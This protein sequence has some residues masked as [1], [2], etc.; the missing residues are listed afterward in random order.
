MPSP[1]SQCYMQIDDSISIPRTYSRR[2]GAV[3]GA[4][5]PQGASGG[6]EA[7]PCGFHTTSDVLAASDLAGDL[8]V[9][10]PW[11]GH[12]VCV[13]FN[14]QQLLST[15]AAYGTSRGFR[16]PS[17]GSVWMDSG[18]VW[19]RRV[20]WEPLRLWWRLTSLQLLPEKSTGGQKSCLW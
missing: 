9:A 17:P 7:F 3:W 2:L 4:K 5:T 16:V 8:I 15:P 20:C 6:R 12:R 13:G 1:P 10:V 18:Q 11:Q 19:P 14:F